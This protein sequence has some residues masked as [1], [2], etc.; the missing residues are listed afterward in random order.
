M[1]SLSYL[2]KANRTTAF[3]HSRIANSTFQGWTYGNSLLYKAFSI[4]N[5]RYLSI[6]KSNYQQAKSGVSFRPSFFDSRG[7]D[8]LDAAYFTGNPE[9]YKLIGQI[10]ELIRLH[11]LHGVEKVEGIAYP[12]WYSPEELDKYG[13]IAL[14]ET[15]N[16]DLYKKLDLLFGHAI[17]NPAVHDFL[18]RLAK[19]NFDELLHTEK[20]KFVEVDEDGVASSKASRKTAKVKA[21]IVPGEGLIYINGRPLH[22][23]FMNIRYRKAVIRPLEVV[24]AITKFNVWATVEE[25]GQKTQAE[26]LSVAIA[27]AICAFEDDSIDQSQLKRYVKIDYR[28]NERKKTG[29]PG[30]RKKNQWLRR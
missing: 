24:G 28:Q 2:L 11:R 10:N 1:H 3:V 14:N 5:A 12:N 20:K 26:G 17:E 16:K 22:E 13:G 30:A 21:S 8:N 4:N 27:R 19:G 6:S 18:R 7:E 25:G 29:Q 23:H 15:Q 9:Y